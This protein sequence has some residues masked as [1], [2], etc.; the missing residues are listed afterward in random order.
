MKKII[1]LWQDK[2]VTHDAFTFKN[3]AV[4]IITRPH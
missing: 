4:R 2:Q 1:V 3:F